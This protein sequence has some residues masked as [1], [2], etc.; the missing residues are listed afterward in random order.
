MKREEAQKRA[1]SLYEQLNSELSGK[2]I[3]VVAG[4]LWQVAKQRKGEQPKKVEQEI[5][6]K[7]KETSSNIQG[8]VNVETPE[9]QKNWEAI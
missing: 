2:D 3:C 7:P 5:I 1:E 9:E 6:E 4:R 8:G